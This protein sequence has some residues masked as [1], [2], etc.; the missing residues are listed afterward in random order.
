MCEEDLFCIFSQDFEANLWLCAEWRF[1][2]TTFLS[3]Y[4]SIIKL[5][6]MLHNWTCHVNDSAERSVKAGNQAG[7]SQ[8]VVDWSVAGTVWRTAQGITSSRRE[9][10]HVPHSHCNSHIYRGQPVHD[11]GQT[12][13]TGRSWSSAHCA[14][15]LCFKVVVIP[16]VWIHLRPYRT[17]AV[18]HAFRTAWGGAGGL[19]AAFH[20]QAVVVLHLFPEEILKAFDVLDGVP[21]DLHFGKTLTGVC[22]GAAP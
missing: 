1:A 6:K 4:E 20:W 14:S 2:I 11:A 3:L 7:V 5:S 15:I 18:N 17:V 19:R 13:Q 9:S 8:D 21:Q 22:R 16:K 12:L 10:N